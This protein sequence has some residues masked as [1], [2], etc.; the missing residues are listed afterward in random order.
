MMKIGII[1]GSGLDNPNLL[2]N[3][4]EKEIE[5]KY[6]FPSSKITCGKLNGVEVFI[7]ARHGQKHNI[8][9]SQINYRAN[10]AALKLLGCT[11]IIATSAVGSLK[12]EIKPGDL[13]FPNQFIDFTKSRKNTFY[14]KE[15][16][17]V[18]TA[19]SEPFSE[20]LR[21]ILI[22]TA[23]ESGL[24][25][26]PLATVAVIEGPRFS[27]KAESLMFKQFADIIGMT[28]VPEVIL[29]KE[30]EIEYAI[31]AMATDYD[32]WKDNEEPVTFEI[33][34]KKMEENAEKVK[35]LIFKVLEKLKEKNI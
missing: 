27:T 2:E 15:G 31:I 28:A 11:H 18:H 12:E 29:A 17:V 32:C 14:D 19:C 8:P 16:E 1:G 33:V 35:N 30:A 26:H 6:G 13:V 25:H 23:Q 9:P 21:K 5:T 7:L 3:Y 22:E 20:N 34:K 24:S 4:E 10:I